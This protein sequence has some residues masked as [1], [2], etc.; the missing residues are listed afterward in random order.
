MSGFNNFGRNSGVVKSNFAY[1][2]KDDRHR[3]NSSNISSFYD[4]SGVLPV[5]MGGDFPAHK[6]IRSQQVQHMLLHGSLS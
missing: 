2:S 4:N 3:S 1:L 6:F 5:R